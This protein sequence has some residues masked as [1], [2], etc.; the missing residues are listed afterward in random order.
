MVHDPEARPEGH[1][2]FLV[3]SD[4]DEGDA[5]ALL[6][7]DELELGMLAQL[8]VER[9]QRLIEQQQLRA[10]H[11]RPG[12]RHP[13]PLAAGELMRF[14]RT[15]AAHFHDVEDLPDLA[16]DLLA[17]EALLFQSEGHIL[18]DT[19]VREERIGLEHHVD[20]TLVGRDGAHVRAIDANRPGARQLEAGQHP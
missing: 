6:D 13:L 16:A 11:Q 9:R 7:V 19:H 12:Q 3:V 2:F 4:D 8:P 5:Q 18:L 15:E 17:A 1:G 10:L 20:R 14:A